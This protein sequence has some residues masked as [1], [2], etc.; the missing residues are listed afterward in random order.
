MTPFLSLKSLCLHLALACFAISGP[1]I[2]SQQNTQDSSEL[3]LSQLAQDINKSVEH[4][5]EAVRQLGQF[6]GANALIAIAR[7]SRDQHVELRLASIDAVEQWSEVAKWDVVSPLVNDSS[8]EV[9]AA[10]GRSLVPLWSKLNS[11]QQQAIQPAVDH[12]LRQIQ[13]ADDSVATWL[14]VALVA[15]YQQRNL[16]AIKAYQKVLSV[17]PKTE[18]AVIQMAEIY[19]VEGSNSKAIKTLL[20][21]LEEMPKSGAI[22]HSL[23]LSF[24]RD[25]QLKQ[26]GILLKRAVE[27]S[28]NNPQFSYV[29]ALFIQQ[30]APHQAIT[31][32]K[33][34]VENSQSPQHLYAL[35]DLYIQQNDPLAK[36]CLAKLKSLAPASIYQDLQNK[37]SQST[38]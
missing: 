26:A 1:A 2:S 7:A 3:A 9:Q 28:P 17:A 23:G 8:G 24:Y 15:Q 6:S 27:L 35:C 16:T 38:L 5:S 11:Q 30:N 33:H 18:Q 14:E 37:Y 29:Y 12:Y 22:A 21:G 20:S 34:A 4:R 25:Q 10:A 36:P 32:L 19:R 31:L 13:Q